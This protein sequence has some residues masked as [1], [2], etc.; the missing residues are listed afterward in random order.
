MVERDDHKV[1]AIEVKLGS[2]PPD[3]HLR[4]LAWL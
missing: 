3:R 1:L 4:H 2:A